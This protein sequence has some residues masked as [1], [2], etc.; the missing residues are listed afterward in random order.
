[1]DTLGEYTWLVVRM[2]YPVGLLAVS[3]RALALWWMR[4]LR[5]AD[6]IGYAVFLLFIAAAILQ[7]W[8]VAGLWSAVP[9][10]IGAILAALWARADLTRLAAHRAG[11]SPEILGFFLISRDRV[12]DAVR[13]WFA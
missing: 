2:V 10:L 8:D 1:M 13:N 11:D 9:V 6:G 5:V 3:L 7:L 4:R 12:P